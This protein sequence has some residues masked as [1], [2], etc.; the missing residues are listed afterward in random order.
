MEKEY[1]EN[2][3]EFG[4]V[5]GMNMQDWWMG[6]RGQ[7]DDKLLEKIKKIDKSSEED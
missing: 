5:L 7:I 6:L 1:I 2:C 4:R 3:E